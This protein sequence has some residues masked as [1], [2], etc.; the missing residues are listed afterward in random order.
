[1]R[2]KNLDLML[3]LVIVAV[4]VGLSLL[5]N[6]PVFVSIILMLPLVF[7]IPGY[8][9][10]EFVFPR[11]ILQEPDPLIMQ[12]KLKLERPLNSFD[13]ILLS[14]GL[15]LALDVMGGFVLNLLPGGLNAQ[16]W[17]IFLGLATTL[18]ALLAVFFRRGGH[19]GKA[20]LQQTPHPQRPSRSAILS[21]IILV[22]LA[23]T[24]VV[25]SLVYATFGA[26]HQAYAG[27][28]QLWMLPSG[29]ATQSCAVRLGIRNFEAATTTY[30]V[31][32]TMNGVPV[33]TW[34]SIVL[35]PQQEW[36]KLAPITPDATDKAYIEVRLYQ[37]GTSEV[38]YQKVNITF[39][40]TRATSP[41][42]SVTCEAA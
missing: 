33:T 1:M 19:V 21:A 36:D 7:A 38:N 15:S 9:F 8:A 6:R 31:T 29:Q 14:I 34:S 10:G 13:R 20:S 27:F 4:D 35:T 39:H 32:M 42:G 40:V 18:F 26:A 11:R 23:L 24:I 41:A 2:L 28:T 22:M 5:P 37:Q 12:P 30:R 25:A 16:S 3:A 17:A